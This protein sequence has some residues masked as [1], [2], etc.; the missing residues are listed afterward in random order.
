MNGKG[1]GRQPWTEPG[2]ISLALYLP[3]GDF[4][5]EDAVCEHTPVLQYIHDL[6][7]GI[8]EPR[9]RLPVPEPTD[10]ALLSYELLWGETTLGEKPRFGDFV[11]TQRISRPAAVDITVATVESRLRYEGETFLQRQHNEYGENILLSR[12]ELECL[13]QNYKQ[14]YKSPS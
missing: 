8:R 9:L 11:D 3:N 5:K 13:M 6:E 7:N 10:N 1:W 2:I 12:S 14:N 4:I